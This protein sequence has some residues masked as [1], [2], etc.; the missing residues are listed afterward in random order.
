MKTHGYLCITE[1]GTMRLTKKPP[2]LF[3]NEIAVKV[4]VNIPE[5]LF[6]RQFPTVLL[7]LPMDALPAYQ[8]S[9]PDQDGQ[10]DHQVPLHISTPTSLGPIN[11]EVVEVRDALMALVDH[12]NRIERSQHS[13]QQPATAGEEEG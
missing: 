5:E 4:E 12:A 7:D 10:A 11:L 8:H 13:T 2:E 3:A 9:N 1:R 6:R